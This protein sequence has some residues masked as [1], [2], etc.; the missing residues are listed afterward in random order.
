MKHKRIYILPLL[1][2]LWPMVAATSEW[3][4]VSSKSHKL[5]TFKCDNGLQLSK[6]QTIN[7]YMDDSFLHLNCPSELYYEVR[8]TNSVALRKIERT[9]EPQPSLLQEYQML[10]NVGERHNAGIDGVLSLQKV[11]LKLSQISEDA[12]QLNIAE[13]SSPMAHQ[14]YGFHHCHLQAQ[15]FY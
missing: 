2:L 10:M 1:A 13:G 7:C 11:S 15:S 8:I 3:H 12:M 5:F 14:N 4:P 6:I 9:L